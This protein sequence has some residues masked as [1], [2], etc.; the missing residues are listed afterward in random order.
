MTSA[1]YYSPIFLE[2]K[3]RDYHFENP[4]RLKELV[5]AIKKS[6]TLNHI[7]FFE[8]K[9]APEE[10][11]AL[12]HSLNHINRI[13]NLSGYGYLDH[14][15][16]YS[17]LSAKA[18]FTAAGA[19]VMCVDDILKG[20][21]S[22]GFCLVRPPGH[23]AEYD[24]AMGFCLF[25]N[26]AI[27][28][29]YALTK[30]FS[31]IAIVD[32]DVHHGNGTQHSFYGDNNALYISLHRFP[33]YPGTGSIEETGTG[34]GAGFNVN[35]PFPAGAGNA[36]YKSAFDKIVIP[37]LKQYS[38]DLII[39][40]AG[41]DGHI[42]DPLG[43]LSLNEKG[44]AYMAACLSKLDVKNSILFLEG[45]YDLAALV[46]SALKTFKALAD[47]QQIIRYGYQGIYEKRKEPE[48]NVKFEQVIDNVID[49]HRKYWS[50]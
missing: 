31:K 46:S 5:T 47:N 17:P 27:A 35:I 28:A 10:I 14:D 11:I 15:T 19:G 30:G 29:K 48:E 33:F 4:I 12:N 49:H 44:F 2:H 42:S 26:A 3:P 22:N 43:G 21:I 8:P 40:S 50:F 13:K 41:F 23:H 18:A 6:I 38:A 9:E 34:K 37:V 20:K 45:G 36:D 7:P 39:I 16:Y 24:N 25:N 32:F 1:F